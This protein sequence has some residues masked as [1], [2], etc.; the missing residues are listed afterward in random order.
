MGAV[1]HYCTEC[2]RATEVTEQLRCRAC[3]SGRII[4]AAEEIKTIAEECADVLR[5]LAQR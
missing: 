4:K 3:G 2:E 5:R 1:M